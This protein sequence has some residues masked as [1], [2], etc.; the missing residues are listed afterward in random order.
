MAQKLTDGAVAHRY[1]NSLEMVQKLSN[2]EVSATCGMRFL[3]CGLALQWTRSASV[4]GERRNAQ[5]LF[6]T[7]PASSQPCLHLP[8]RAWSIDELMFGAFIIWS[9]LPNLTQVGLLFRVQLQS[10]VRR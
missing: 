2:R 9:K 8:N 1:Y 3:W 6:P 5:M 7:L 4:S 10:G